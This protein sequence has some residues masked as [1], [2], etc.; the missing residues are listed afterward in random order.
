VELSQAKPQSK[1]NSRNTFSG[2]G[3]CTWRQRGM[4]LFMV[5]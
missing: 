1:F 4:V 5:G 3:Y 2:K